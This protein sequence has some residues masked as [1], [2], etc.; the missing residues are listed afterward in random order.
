MRY[1]YANKPVVLEE[2]GWYGGNLESTIKDYYMDQ[3][4][5][6]RWCRLLVEGTMDSVSGW[7]NWPYQDTPT[8]TDTSK[9]SGVFGPEKD[10]KEWGRDFI[11]IIS[12]VQKMELKRVPSERTMKMDRRRVLTQ[13]R[14]DGAWYADSFMRKYMLERETCERLDL[15]PYEE[16]PPGPKP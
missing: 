7:L 14:K 2:F 9:S 5:Q 1:C 15:V 8:S 12:N 6:R 3:N 16:S 11:E 10:L 13:S 4:D